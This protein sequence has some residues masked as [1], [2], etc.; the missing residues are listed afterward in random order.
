M[1]VFWTQRTKAFLIDK[2]WTP[3]GIKKVNVLQ[4]IYDN[5]FKFLGIPMLTVPT[6]SPSI[7]WLTNYEDKI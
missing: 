4:E 2:R 6:K 7:N 1:K 5:K 3:C